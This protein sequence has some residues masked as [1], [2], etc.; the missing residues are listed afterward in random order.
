VRIRLKTRWL[1]ERKFITLVG[2]HLDI[3]KMAL[4]LSSGWLGFLYLEESSSKQAGSTE[5]D[6]AVSFS[7]LQYIMSAQLWI[8]AICSF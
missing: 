3:S 1:E 6:L 5:A 4:A 7:R 2:Q 8:K